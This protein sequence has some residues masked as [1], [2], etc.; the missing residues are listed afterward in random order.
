MSLDIRLEEERV[1]G[2]FD[3]T[4]THNLVPMAEAAGL[5]ECLWHPDRLGIKQA[6][7][8]RPY[9]NGGIRELEKD[10][11]KFVA[12]E[13]ENGW[14]TYEGFLSTLKVL[15]LACY[16]HDEARVVVSR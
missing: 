5:Y 4:I 11:D 2:V 9:L 16:K 1:T 15:L 7:Q 13:P 14:G 3:T 6:G 12:M 10:P 8:L